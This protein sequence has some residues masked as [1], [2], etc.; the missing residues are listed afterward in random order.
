MKVIISADGNTIKM[1]K[2]L[3]SMTCPAADL[4]RWVKLYTDLRDRAGKRF[5]AFYEQDVADLIKAQER[6]KGRAAA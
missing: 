1:R 5:A 4:P 6:L 2:R 3:W